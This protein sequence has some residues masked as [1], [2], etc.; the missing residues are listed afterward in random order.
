MLCGLSLSSGAPSII[1]N[2]DNSGKR[3]ESPTSPHFSHRPPGALLLLAAYPNRLGTLPRVVDPVDRLHPVLRQVGNGAVRVRVRRIR[4]QRVRYID[5][6]PLVPPRPVTPYPVPAY[7]RPVLPLPTSIPPPRQS[8][9]SA[10]TIPHRR[11]RYRPHPHHQLVPRLP[12]LLRYLP[13]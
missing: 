3:Q 11:Q 9:A 6:R 1:W 13:R 10:V 7:P 4:A 12:R 2:A 8:L 5:P